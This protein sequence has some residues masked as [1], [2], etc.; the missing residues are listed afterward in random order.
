MP[1]PRLTWREA[2]TRFGSD[3]PDLRF[4]LEICDLSDLVADSDFMVFTSALDAGGSV[5]AITVPEGSSLSRK[6]IDSLGEYVKTYRAKG[7]AWLVPAPEPR[8]SFL[9]FTTPELI[10][11]FAERCQAGPDDLILII[12]DKDNDTV[13][14]ALGELRLEVARRLDL[15]PAGEWQALWVTE[16]PLFEY[17]DENQRLV[18]VHHPFTSPLEEDLALLET[19]PEQVR[20]QAYDIV[21]NGVEL[22]GGS[23]RIHDQELQKR[24]FKLLGLGPEVVEERFGFLLEAF[25]Y[26][27]PPHGGIAYGLDRMVMLLAEQS[28]IREVIAFPKV[29]N[30]SCLLTSAPSAVDERQLEELGLILRDL[31]L[32]ELDGVE[33]TGIE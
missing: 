10:N 31:P 13:L 21:L 2:M 29:Q 30:S 28:S 7:L 8:G 26:G 19:A 23:I 25:Q 16:F 33:Q 9:K 14:T 12:A 1:L 4:G 17:D 15:I 5:R 20:A 11:N 6:Q 27:V 32:I 24:M 3:K 22:G 18:A